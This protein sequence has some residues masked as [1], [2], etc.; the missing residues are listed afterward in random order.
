MRIANRNINSLKLI[1]RPWWKLIVYNNRKLN[2][3]II[4]HMLYK[5]Q[6]TIR[7]IF[8]PHL[9]MAIFCELDLNVTFPPLLFQHNISK[10]LEF[11]DLLWN[12][13]Q[14]ESWCKLLPEIQSNP[15][16][17]AHQLTSNYF[18]YNCDAHWATNGPQITVYY[19]FKLNFLYY[20]VFQMSLQDENLYGDVQLCKGQIQNLEWEKVTLHR[21]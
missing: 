11:S 6:S 20:V 1:E 4:I 12:K 21:S 15:Y 16:Q 17:N 14:T 3:S 2:Y 7:V 18:Q 13:S 10:Y 19:C 5:G 8:G 9:Q